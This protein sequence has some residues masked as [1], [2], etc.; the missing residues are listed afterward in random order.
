[1]PIDPNSIAPG[2]R[3]L[4]ATRHVRTILEVTADR[5]R[6]AYGDGSTGG[7]GQWRWQTKAKFAN[8]AA[9]EVSSDEAAEPTPPRIRT[10]KPESAEPP[11]T[12]DQKSSASRKILSKT[13]KS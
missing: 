1:M 9:R 3:Y 10:E 13:I 7:V 5:V 2:K 4:T 6:Y 12:N 8:D 11:G